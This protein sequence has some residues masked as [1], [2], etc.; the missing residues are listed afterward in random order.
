MKVQVVQEYHVVLEIVNLQNYDSLL[1]VRN[2]RYL[3]ILHGKTLVLS[4]E[5]IDKK[6][7]FFCSNLPK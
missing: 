2:I 4:N 7:G 3:N 5:Q 1:T 6:D